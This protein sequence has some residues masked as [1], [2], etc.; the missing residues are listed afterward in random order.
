MEARA[1]A[2]VPVF[3]DQNL[4]GL[5]GAYQNSGPRNWEES[6]VNALAQIGIQ[7]GAVLKQA[8]SVNQIRRQA[9]QLTKIAKREKAAKEQ[10]QQ[11]ASQLLIAVRPTLNG[12]LTVRA[13]IT[14]DEV[15]TIADAYNNT[16]QSLR[17]IAVQLQQASRKVAQTSQAS[18]SDLSALAT[19]AQE[20]FQAINRA[21]DQIGAMLHS[22]E[23]VAT[24]AQ[25]VELAA[26]RT[27]QTVRQGDAAMNRTVEAILDVQKNVTETSTR[28]QRLSESSQK[29]SKVVSL[30]GNFTT[31]TQLL[32]INAAIE[33]TRAGEYG[34]G[35][36]VV[37]DEVRALARQSAAATTEISKLVQEIQ[38][39]TTAVSTAMSTGLQ[40][41]V[42]GTNLVNETRQSLNAIVEATTEISQLVE[43]ITQAT[44]VQKGQSESVTQTMTD[45]ATIASRTSEDSLVLSASFNELLS[46]AQ[47]L[48]ASVERFK[49][50]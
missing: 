9:E 8:D 31:Q 50:E 45:V 21:L 39:S 48:Q 18:E 37:A 29:I 20:Q 12:D 33:A 46:V 10:L 40:Q 17:R 7:V 13:P 4:W 11:R 14:E 5:M 43:G 38:E 22:T 19:Q 25:Q 3:V 15:G 32:A 34:R 26:Q 6:D 36:A 1:Y 44:Q 41:V 28:L 24:N 27:N 23:A 30:I 49:V 16:L 35:F 2:I 47:T 42:T